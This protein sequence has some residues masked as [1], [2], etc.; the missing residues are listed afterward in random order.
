MQYMKSWIINMHTFY[1][2]EYGKDI[3]QSFKQ[4]PVE[5]NNTK[6]QRCYQF[7]WENNAKK[8]ASIWPS[9]SQ[10]AVQG[11][12]PPQW[13]WATLPP[14]SPVEVVERVVAQ[15]GEGEGLQVVAVVGLPQS[16]PLGHQ[17]VQVGA[18]KALHTPVAQ[19]SG[20]TAQHLQG[21]GPA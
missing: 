8:Q 4:N 15:Q 7:W 9:Q 5:N 20:H 12:G 13:V 21:R 6:Q 16:Q 10:D 19:R 2:Y 17:V 18:H 3:P 1:E 14:S 11:Q